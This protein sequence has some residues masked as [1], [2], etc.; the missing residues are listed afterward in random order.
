MKEIFSRAFCSS[1]IS[2]PQLK[3]TK[4]TVLETSCIFFQEEGR[5]IEIKSSENKGK[6]KKEEKRR[7]KNTSRSHVGIGGWYSLEEKQRERERNLE[8]GICWI[9]HVGCNERGNLAMERRAEERKKRRE[10][11]K[12]EKSVRE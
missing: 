8:R 11:G 10:V 2:Y 9:G 3:V 5:G 1:Y 7:R 4:S 12:G 6:A